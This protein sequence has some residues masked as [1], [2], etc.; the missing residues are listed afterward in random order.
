MKTTTAYII[1]NSIVFLAFLSFQ[2]VYAQSK[3]HGSVIDLNGKPIP[4]AN[5]LLLNSADS[6]LVKGTVTNNAGIY[7]FDKIAIGK[8]FIASTYTGLEQHYTSLL[9]IITTHDDIEAGTLKLLQNNA[10]LTNVTVFAKKP[11]YEQKID[12]LVINVEN[13]I[14]SAGNTALE[15]LERSPGVVVDHQNNS[16]SMNGKDGVVLMI[17]GKINYMPISAVVQ[18]LSG[19]SAGNIE[20]IELITTPPANFD[21]A[22]N[23]GYINI[24]LK[25]DNN[26]GTNGSFSG[27]LGYGKGW[28][29]EASFNFNHRKGKVNLYGDLSY[30]RIRKPFP[31]SIYTKVS[32]NGNITETYFT[33]HRIDTT[34]NFNA[35]LGLDYQLNN[36]T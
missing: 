34:K 8:Y 30:S 9:H 29:T 26:Y 12:R 20:K 21:A 23:A 2:T 16:I 28:V 24:L 5:V 36:N 25:A 17:N 4:S 33:H 1:C 10:V 15:V 35:R 27:S 19:M 3:I 7:Y 22:G 31:A 11:L 18:L 32:N 13:S 14:T 6:S